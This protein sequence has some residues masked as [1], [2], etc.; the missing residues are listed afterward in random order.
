MFTDICFPSSNEQEFIAVAEKIGTGSL[1]FIYKDRR[2]IKGIRLPKTEKINVF[3]G[4]IEKK[5]GAFEQISFADS[6]KKISYFSDARFPITQVHIKDLAVLGLPLVL[7]VGRIIKQ[8]NPD[9]RKRLPLILLLC[10]KYKVNV[11]AASSAIFPYDLIPD[12]DIVSAL[13]ILGAKDKQTK[14]GVSFLYTLLTN[15]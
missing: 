9:I 4:F 13:K 5:T 1:F 3:I 11:I 15:K 10:H 12:K 7:P 8:K 2:I 6:T 14:E